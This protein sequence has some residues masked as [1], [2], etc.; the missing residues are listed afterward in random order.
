MTLRV[1]Y[2]DYFSQH[3]SSNHP[4]RTTVPLIFMIAGMILFLADSLFIATGAASSMDHSVVTLMA[5]LRTGAMVAVSRL[6][7][8]IGSTV[9]TVIIVILAAAAFWLTKHQVQAYL[10]VGSIIG[11]AIITWIIKHLVHR[12]RP[13]ATYQVGTVEDP[14]S[15]PSGHSVNSTVLYGTL[16]I[17]VLY[18]A[19][20]ATQRIWATVLC[21]LMPLFVG[22]SRI[23]L[24]QHWTTDVLAGWILGIFWLGIVGLA[25]KYLLGPLKDKRQEALETEDEQG[26][27]S[28]GQSHQERR[29][30]RVASSHR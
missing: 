6:F 10:L 7:T 27:Q 20:T 17:I 15:F 12:A 1:P 8:T 19:L 22:L 13:A 18:S 9:A 14:Y 24:C 26:H 25:A 4:V 2:N 23:V 11:S 5:S 29:R 28:K 16:A 30:P 3:D 21:V